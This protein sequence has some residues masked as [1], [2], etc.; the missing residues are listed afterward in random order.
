ML[1]GKGAKT[2]FERFFKNLPSL[3]NNVFTFGCTQGM[4][5]NRVENDRIFF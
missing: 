4:Y 1:V 5:E 3:V 2:Y